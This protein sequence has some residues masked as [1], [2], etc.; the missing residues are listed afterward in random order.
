MRD[1]NPLI[2]IF[3]SLSVLFIIGYYVIYSTS[4]NYTIIDNDNT[5]KD[6]SMY[7]LNNKRTYFE[8]MV[9][10]DT[11]IVYLMYNY[12]YQCGVTVMYNSD[13]S[14]MTVDKLSD[15]SE[16]PDIQVI[17]RFSR[18]EKGGYDD[19]FRYIVDNN[20]GIVY[21][22]YKCGYR[23]ALTAMYNSDGSVMT[24]DDIKK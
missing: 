12:G 7:Y 24:L 9:D 3:L 13:G 6:V 5:Y 16:T 14:I 8:Y 1:N 22:L 10:H 17:S 21:S 19:S 15:D 23:G 18:Y 20:T 4:K 11:N 2:V